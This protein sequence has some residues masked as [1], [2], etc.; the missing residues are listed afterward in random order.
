MRIDPETRR[1]LADALRAGVV[2]SI[3]GG[4]FMWRGVQRPPKDLLQRIHQRALPIREALG[5]AKP[6]AG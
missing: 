4:K 1:V 5:S 3:E 2:F 6:E